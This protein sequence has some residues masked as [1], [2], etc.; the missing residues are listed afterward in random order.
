MQRTFGAAVTTAAF[1]SI[2]SMVAAGAAGPAAAEGFRVENDSL[3]LG[4]VIAGRSVSAVYTF[5]NG[6]NDKVRILN[7]KPSC[8]CT[9]AEFDPVI[10]PGGSGSLRAE[11]ST[12]PNQSGKL[13]KSIYVETDAPDA[14]SILLRFTVAIEQPIEAR[15]RLKLVVTGTEGREASGGILLRRADGVRLEIYES[16][17]DRPG[18]SVSTEKV[19]AEGTFGD[20]RAEPGDV[21]LQLAAAAQQPVGVVSGTIRLQ[22][23]HPRMSELE[24]PYTLRVRPLME[25][26]PDVVRLWPET[27]LNMPGRF[28]IIGV[29]R[30][31]GAEFSI[32]AVESSLPEVFSAAAAPEPG[33]RYQ[34]V[35]VDLADELAKED[36]M[37]SLDGRL[38]IRTDDPDKPVLTVP[39]IV[40]PTRA[41]TR[42]SPRPT[43]A[44]TPP[45]G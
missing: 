13:S 25:V 6:S 40:A 30:V 36:F 10:Q 19:E 35:R 16:A 39:V 4:P 12:L 37:G 26:R 15:P 44:N 41:L 20:Q 33:S 43:P 42:R 2:L 34:R 27:S 22:T 18:L 45:A 3:V 9:V 38:T 29:S 17:A 32:T 31:D 28:A 21:W 8:G 24:V 11:I 14:R 5:H 23:N 7:A 1:F